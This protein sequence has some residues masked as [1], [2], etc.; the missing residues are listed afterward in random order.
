MVFL[1]FFLQHLA[2]AFGGGVWSVVVCTSYRLEFSNITCSLVRPQ[3]HSQVFVESYGAIMEFKVIHTSNSNIHIQPNILNN[4]ILSN[5][6]TDPGYKY[7]ENP[8]HT[9]YQGSSTHN[10]SYLS[11]FLSLNQSK[12]NS[13]KPLSLTALATPSLTS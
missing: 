11:S 8:T 1:F 7:T 4:T 5:K 6:L 12:F 9:P 10:L 13:P 2:F 3:L